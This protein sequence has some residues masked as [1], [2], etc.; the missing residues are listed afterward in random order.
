M[1][2]YKRE[3]EYKHEPDQIRPDQTDQPSP[4][5]ALYLPMNPSSSHRITSHPHSTPSLSLQKEP[6]RV[7][8]QHPHHPSS[9][10]LSLSPT[11]PPISK[12]FH[13][14]SR[15]P[16]TSTSTPFPLFQSPNTGQ[17]K[18]QMQRLHP[19]PRVKP[20]PVPVSYSIAITSCYIFLPLNF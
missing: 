20:G 10:S 1:L 19:I 2:K 6:H 13:C 7:T 9:L 17:K 5:N 11:P 3:R 15:R 4:A 14:H 16:S 18:S 8:S 12:S